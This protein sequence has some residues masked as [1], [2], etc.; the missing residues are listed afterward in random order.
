[1]VSLTLEAPTDYGLKNFAVMSWAHSPSRQDIACDLL[2]PF[3]LF[4][5]LPRS[6]PSLP[7]ASLARPA[8]RVANTHIL[9]EHETDFL[10]RAVIKLDYRILVLTLGEWRAVTK[11]RHRSSQ[12]V[13]K[14]GLVCRFAVSWRVCACIGGGAGFQKEIW[15]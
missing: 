14:T 2:N 13:E 7:S 10:E 15:P 8:P 9:A 12:G 5:Y 3:L 1:M 4:L 11:D 6:P